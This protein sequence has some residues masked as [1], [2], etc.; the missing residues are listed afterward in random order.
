MSEYRR[1][2]LLLRLQ[3]RKVYGRERLLN[4]SYCWYVVSVW[5]GVVN[6]GRVLF[7]IYLASRSIHTRVHK[8]FPPHCHYLFDI[9]GL[10]E[11]MLI[12]HICL[13]HVVS[14]LQLDF[15]QSFLFD[16]EI[17]PSNQ[18]HGGPLAEDH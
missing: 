6:H 18:F 5:L 4:I 3:I 14:F 2:W 7:P 10:P 16:E 1:R 9:R 13:I 15:G 12:V 11:A 17:N 8:L